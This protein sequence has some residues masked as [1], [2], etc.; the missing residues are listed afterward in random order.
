MCS[1]VRWG[2]GSLFLLSTMLQ[3]Y[4]TA[5]FHSA[6]YTFMAHRKI[7]CSVCISNETQ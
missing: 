3:L 1:E 5:I 6:L 2:W 7:H 4:L